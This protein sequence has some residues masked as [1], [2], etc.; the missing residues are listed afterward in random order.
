MMQWETTNSRVERL[1][2]TTTEMKIR[3]TL[4]SDST[5]EPASKWLLYLQPRTKLRCSPGCR[6][7][8][9]LILIETS[10]LTKN[11]S[12]NISDPNPSGFQVLNRGHIAGATRQLNLSC[13]EHGCVVIRVSI[14]CHRIWKSHHTLNKFFAL[15][16][17]INCHCSA[18]ITGVTILFLCLCFQPPKTAR[19]KQR[20]S[21]SL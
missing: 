4:L 2:G 8:S 7:S 17:N 19:K 3:P 14:I 18:V 10:C 15:L 13:A 1:R 5:A 6:A 21:A 12:G 20:L 16:W 11:T 9:N